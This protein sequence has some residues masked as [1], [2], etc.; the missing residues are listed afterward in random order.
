MQKKNS[1]GQLFICGLG[2]NRVKDM[3]LQTL[4]TLRACDAVYYIHGDWRAARAL[5]SPLALKLRFFEDEKFYAL[6]NG[7]RIEAAGRE[8]C[9]KL[10][11][12]ATVGYLT[13][14]N[15]MLLSDGSSI[16]S[17]CE[18]KGHKGLALTAPS[19]VDSILSLM[20]EQYEI[21]S[22]GFHVYHAEMILGQPASLTTAATVIALCVDDCIARKTF[23]GF[24]ARVEAVYP[25]GHLLY[26]VRCEDGASR[27]ELLTIPAGELRKMEG[28]I[29]YMMS[30]VLPCIAPQPRGLTPGQKKKLFKGR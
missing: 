27:G 22:R 14:G 21:F 4:K 17:Y 19:S 23:A 15:P 13:Y 30:L 18:E 8:I 29:S 1:R 25:P 28:R 5:L 26:A 16:L 11:K 6:P 7:E 20:T 12:G 24:C 10:E 9:R 2:V 3:T